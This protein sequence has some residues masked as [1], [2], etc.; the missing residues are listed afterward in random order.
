MLPGCLQHGLPGEFQV[1]AL[2]DPDRYFD[3]SPGIATGPVG[4]A[5][6]DK[7]LVGN[8]HL[9]AIEGFTQRKTGVSLANEAT[10]GAVAHFYQ[11]VLSD[12]L[13]QQ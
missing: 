6:G 4:Y 10:A 5:I 7:I 3:S 12:Q 8:H 9:L 1:G 11:I 13:F 2:G